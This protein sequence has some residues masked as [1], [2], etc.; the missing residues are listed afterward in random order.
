[1]SLKKK[2]TI[3]D[4]P[5]SHRRVLLRVDF[6]VPLDPVSGA[7][8]D[9]TRIRACLPTSHYL[10][11]HQAKIIICS[12]LG[13]PE[14]PDPKFSLAPIAQ[15][16]SRLLGTSVPLMGGCVGPEVERAVEEL[17]PG[18][19]LM[20]ENLRFHP[21]EEEND[22]GFAQALSRLGEL[23]VNDAFGISHRAHASTVGVTKFLP[24][25]AGFLLEKELEFLDQALNNVLRPFAA[26]LGGA[27]VS[28][29]IKVLENLLDR[30]DHLLI[31]GGM[32]ATCLKAK[33][34]EVGVSKVEEDK[35]DFITSL[36]HKAQE[37]QVNLLVPQDLVVAENFAEEARTR[38]V[39]AE[40]VPL[41][42]CIMDI[43]PQTVALFTEHLRKCETV[44]WNGP[45]GVFEMAPFAVGTRA[46]AQVL[47]ELKA[48]TI[49]GGGSTAEAVAAL[50]LV[51]KMSH[52]STGGGASLEFLEGQT[53]PG[54]AALADR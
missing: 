22:E 18:Q 33:G 25:V 50:G 29:K 49:V 12:H 10:V 1:M 24:A 41:G 35:L 6:N 21:G 14:G 30:V 36:Q 32:A 19:L 20:L 16:L 37:R 47:A 43:G 40:Q 52:V 26:V 27:K 11:E 31:G 54:V 38:I 34:Y 42:W 8:S 46:I 51:E 4:V 44:L 23:Y 28:D 53:L 15:H 39:P 5:V 45:M 2:K 3:R 13:R 9:D 48:T 7:I 17:L